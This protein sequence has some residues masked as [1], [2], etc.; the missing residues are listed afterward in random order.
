MGY[1][2]AVVVSA[3]SSNGYHFEVLRSE[4]GETFSLIMTAAGGP[5]CVI[6][7][8]TDWED[9]PFAAPSVPAS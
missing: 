9:I 1:Q 4:N 8:G 3:L 7:A 2:E 5:T 6:G